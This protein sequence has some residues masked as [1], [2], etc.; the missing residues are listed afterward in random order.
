MKIPHKKIKNLYL[1]LSK[2]FLKNKFKNIELNL[3]KTLIK[4]IKN[5][6]CIF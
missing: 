6:Y 2:N 1:N 5:N 4:T 3:S